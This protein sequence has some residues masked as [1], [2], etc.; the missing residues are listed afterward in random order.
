MHLCSGRQVDQEAGTGRSIGLTVSRVIIGMKLPMLLLLLSCQT[1]AQG[2]SRVERTS[3]KLHKVSTTEYLGGL[4]LLFVVLHW[5]LG[6][7]HSYLLGSCAAATASKGAPPP[8][9]GSTW[10][11][12]KSISS[13][14]DYTFGSHHVCG[15]ST[16]R[17]H[18]HDMQHVLH[19]GLTTA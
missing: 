3:I 12:T 18:H 5:L 7:S 11:A 6:E 16:M 4:Y 8:L 17:T 9:S 2:L 15:F 19:T 1:P 14:I 13:A 10:I